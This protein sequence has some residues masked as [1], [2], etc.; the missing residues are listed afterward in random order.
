M[1]KIYALKSIIILDH[2]GLLIYIHI[3]YLGFYHNV[4]VQQHSNV[5]R[6]WCQYFMQG[7]EY[8]ELFGDL[9]YMGEE[10][11]IIHKIRWWEI[12]PNVERDGYK[13]TIKYMKA[14]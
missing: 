11:F 8:F 13:H 5:Y 3:N 9:R 14:L 12:V 1:K 2:H 10:M 6:D 4:N 7:D